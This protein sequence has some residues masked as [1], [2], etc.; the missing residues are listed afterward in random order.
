MIELII[1]GIVFVLGFGCISV[2]HGMEIIDIWYKDTW[3]MA[4][5]CFWPFVIVGCVLLAP[6]YGLFLIGRFFRNPEKGIRD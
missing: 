3:I 2:L 5:L 4:L 6:F 1:Y